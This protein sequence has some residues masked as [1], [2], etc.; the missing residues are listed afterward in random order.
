MTNKIQGIQDDDAVTI[1]V[2]GAT[3]MIGSNIIRRIISEKKCVKVVACV[4]NKEKAMLKF[5]EYYDNP[6]F[7]LLETDICVPIEFEDSVD[8]IVHTAGV[9]GGSKQ[10]IDYP[11]RTINTAIQGTVNVLEYARKHN[12]RGVLFF[13]S[14]E[15]YGK[16]DTSV[17]Y[18][19]EKDGGYIDPTNVRSS[20]SESK[21]MCECICVSYAKQYGMNV[22]IARPTA[23][24]GAG[25][26]YNDG[27]VFAQ[28]ARS[29]IEK[30]DIVLKSTGET[31]RNYCDVED[32]VDAILLLLE[33][34]K[35]GEAYNIANMET[36]ISIKDF[37]QKFITLFPEASI[38]LKFD[39][40]EDPT[41]FGYNQTMRAVLNATKLMELGWKPKHSLDDTIIQLVKSMQESF[42]L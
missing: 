14:L 33:K 26:D 32:C 39:L 21:R 25:V 9:T 27:R 36:E 16:V 30:R 3:G 5:S 10:H 28:F 11:M 35:S 37:A 19:Y 4:R 22:I 7:R 17:G 12:V 13:S 1:L 29:V 23:T 38:E 31:V 20:Y 24:F 8:Y 15:I 18:I 2:T 40:S 42:V 41:K 34:G 6:R